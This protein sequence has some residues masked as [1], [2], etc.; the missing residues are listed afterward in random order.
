MLLPWD[1]SECHDRPGRTFDM[2]HRGLD[3]ESED[4]ITSRNFL[5]SDWETGSPAA[6]SAMKV[7]R[8]SVPDPDSLWTEKK[9]G[10]G[11]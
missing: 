10:N 11:M 8:I 6:P 1:R 2:G 3:I 4:P 5:T 7:V 9:K